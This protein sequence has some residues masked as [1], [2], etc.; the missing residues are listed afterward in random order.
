LLYAESQRQARHDS[1]TGLLGHRVF[2]EALE[3][4][5]VGVRPFSI[6]LFDIDDFKQINDLHG[7]E[8]G[9]R[10]LQLVSEALRGGTRGG[11]TVF[12]IGGEEFCALLPGLQAGDALGVAEKLRRRVADMISE[13]PVPITVSVGAASFPTH[14]AQR[15]ALVAAADGAMYSAKRGGKNRTSIAGGAG[16]QDARA[17]QRDA[18][19]VLLHGK[20]PDTASHSVH[21][22]ILSVEL[23]DVLSLAPEQL[24]RLRTAA[25]L[26]DIG[27]IAVPDAIL[28]KPG[29]LD[30]EE[31][32][33][34]RTHP[35]VGS[36]L[37][38]SWGL[39]E[40]ATIVRQH[41][42]RVD[43]HGYPG[44][45]TGEEIQIEARIIHV[46]DAYMAMTNDRPY[47]RALPREEALAELERHAGTQFDPDVVSALVARERG[48][49]AP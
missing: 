3:A 2:H 36:E 14:G 6:L 15:G 10:A 44:G 30:E 24:E 1:L 27:K 35:L 45:L 4:E 40:A 25:R 8:M 47:R 26:H 20:D 42:E 16:G 48:R 33:I 21:A 34:V 18:G 28:S 5:I 22:A 29:R 41:H 9:D 38:C 32:R 31:F 11:D 13:L 46:A 23:G 39:H 37:L 17:R 43:G 7:H 49:A 12:R 19:L